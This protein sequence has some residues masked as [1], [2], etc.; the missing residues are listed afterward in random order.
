MTIVEAQYFPAAVLFTNGNTWGRVYAIIARGGD[1]DGLHIWQTPNE[2]P[3]F[4]AN[5]QWGRTTIPTLFE[6]RNGVDVYTDQGLVV[7]TSG[8][9]CRCGS[10]ARWAG[11]RWA[12]T[13]AA[14]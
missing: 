1:E 14:R 7:I 6:A 2:E 3:T 5:I 9:G 12:T 4:R 8:G 13:V 10:L 11:P